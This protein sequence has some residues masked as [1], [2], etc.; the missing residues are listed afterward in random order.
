[1]KHKARLENSL[2]TMMDRV[3]EAVPQDELKEIMMLGSF[4]HFFRPLTFSF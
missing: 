4:C 2:S 3:V 1:M